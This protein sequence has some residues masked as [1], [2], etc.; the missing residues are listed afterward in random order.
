[1]S[2]AGDLAAVLTVTDVASALCAE[3]IVII[4]LDGHGLTKTGAFHLDAI[5]EVFRASFA[6]E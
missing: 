4:D 5:L 1:M 3:E 2:T 6:T